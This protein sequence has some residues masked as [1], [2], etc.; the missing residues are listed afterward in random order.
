MTLKNVASFFLLIFSAYCG[1]YIFINFDWQKEQQVALSAERPLFTSKGIET[2]SYNTEG[3]RS[4]QLYS[5]YLEHF[6]SSDETHF[7]A[8]L[9]HTFKEGRL[10]EWRVSAN[11]AVLEKKQFLVM[12]GKVEIHNLLPNSQVKTITT[13]KMTLDLSSRDFWTDTDIHITGANFTTEGS[14][15]KG[16]F[17]SQYMELMEQVKTVYESKIN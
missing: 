3:V 1:Y 2:T 14:S 17:D 13:E 9:L 15:A 5:K 8:P 7:E 11:N 12:T 16:N 10:K 4:Y 6:T